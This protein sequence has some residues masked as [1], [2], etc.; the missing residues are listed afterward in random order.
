MQLSSWV[1]QPGSR[2]IARVGVILAL[3]ATGV[4]LVL[5]VWEVPIMLGLLNTGPE[6]TR[7][8]DF[9]FY[10]SA[11][12]RWLST[13]SF[14]LP[15][16][17]AGPYT[18]VLDRDV[19]YPPIAL[20]LFVPFALGVPA[21][22]FWV[23]P[24]AVLGY[25]ILRWR[26]AVWTWPVLAAILFWHA[27]LSDL[28]L[29]NTDLWV[30]AAVA[31]GLMWGW[32]SLLVALKPPFGLLALV[33]AKRRSWWVGLPFVVVASVLM[34]RLWADYLVT[35]RNSGI[36]WTYSLPTLPLVVAPLV[37]RLGRTNERTPQRI[38]A[39]TH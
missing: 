21:P 11:A 25:A 23:I 27:T 15:S 18:I 36:P 5:A 6:W 37:A 20:Y 26:P 10:R 35:L 24:L 38:P 30:A 7:Q 19:L 12:Q 33:G 22:L 13:G 39:A 28:L 8:S 1:A 9:N 32:P 34:A 29:G 16:Q 4:F 14:Y 3:T 31:G 17:L 2:A